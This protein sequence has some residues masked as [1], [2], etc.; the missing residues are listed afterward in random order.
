MRNFYL[1]FSNVTY[2]HFFKDVFLVPYYLSK[3]E[4]F[5]NVSIVFPENDNNTAL[6]CNYRG[7][8]LINLKKN[9][10]SFEI[11]VTLVLV[12]Y[13]LK[14]FKKMDNL[15]LFHFSNQT[16][17]ISLF[18]KLLRPKGFLYI[19]V[20]GDFWIE[21]VLELLRKK[22]TF[23]TFLVKKLLLI[24]LKKVNK[25]SVESSNSFDLIN[26]DNQ[27]KA[28]LK[29]KTV[30]LPNCFDEEE[31]KTFNANVNDFDEKENL[32]ITVG[33]LGSFE[34]NTEMFLEALIDLNLSDWRV[35]LIGNIENK[36]QDFDLYIKNF[37]S[38]NPHLKDKVYFTGQINSRQE[39]YEWYNKA[40]VFV[41]TSRYE[42]FCIS[43]VEAAR[44]N[45]IIVSTD[46]SGVKDIERYS[47]VFYLEQNN[48]VQL[49]EKLN[50]IINHEINP[51][52]F[53][54]KEPYDLFYNVKIIN[55]FK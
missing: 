48:S 51:D 35:V 21:R 29:N 42:G 44:F 16:F 36:E 27:L 39:L 25:V 18:F 38:Q 3:E 14:H 20:D 23:K 32:I 17:I 31:F 2:Q 34:K 41:L 4:N 47:P 5:D 33:R 43:L 46:V 15:M 10:L 30:L 13:L 45:N 8:N 40:K 53:K 49:S 12:F 6:P 28:L 7:V 55:L 24:T 52:I 37:M 50:G 19:K 1:L 22:T 54:E 26:S 11:H 9:F